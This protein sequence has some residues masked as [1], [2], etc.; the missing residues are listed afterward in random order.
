MGLKAR[1]AFNDLLR[2]SSSPALPLLHGGTSEPCAVD[3]GRHLEDQLEQDIAIARRRLSPDRV[4]AACSGD[5]LNTD[6]T[7][8]LSSGTFT[9]AMQP[10]APLQCTCPALEERLEGLRRQ[11]EAVEAQGESFFRTALAVEAECRRLGPDRGMS[12]EEIGL[13]AE[14]VEGLCRAGGVAEFPNYRS[15]QSTPRQL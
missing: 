4:R 6:C 1:G 13:A 3:K 15:D 10:R 2:P 8:G 12:G 5:S 11:M 14:P 9:Q 7:P